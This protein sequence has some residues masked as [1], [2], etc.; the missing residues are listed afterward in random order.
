MEDHLRDDAAR[1][2]SKS[3]MLM[4][5]VNDLVPIYKRAM[6]ENDLAGMADARNKMLSLSGKMLEAVYEADTIMAAAMRCTVEK[7]QTHDLERQRINK[8]GVRL[9]REIEQRLAEP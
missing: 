7:R 6:Q 1:N 4:E 3:A 5:Q 2:L 8:F 9:I